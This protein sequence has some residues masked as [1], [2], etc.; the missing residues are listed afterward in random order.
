MAEPYHLTLPPVAATAAP[1][2]VDALYERS[3]Q[4]SRMVP[5]MYTF[6]ANAPGLLETY[7][8][9]YNRFRAESGFS[10]IEQEVVFLAISRE[11]ECAYCLAAHSLVAD[12]MSKVPRA[13]TDAIRDDATVP[14]ERLAVLASFV[15]HLVSTRGRPEDDQARAFLAAGFTER[16]ILYLILSIAVKTISN[17]TNHL[18]ETPVDAAFKV[19]EWGVYRAAQAVVEAARR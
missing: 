15:R 14:D 17:Y 5:N 11:H 8:D 16:Q 3:R 2:A 7:M 10:A 18:C 19:R 1:P 9:G 12:V 4:A 13:V 6:M